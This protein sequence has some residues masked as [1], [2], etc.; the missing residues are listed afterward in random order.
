MSDGRYCIEKLIDY[1][2]ITKTETWRRT[3]YCSD[4]YS[5]LMNFFAD[6]MQ[7]VDTKTGKVMDKRL[8]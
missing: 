5:A 2:R 7:I 1:D 3:N 8:T 4:K 6:D